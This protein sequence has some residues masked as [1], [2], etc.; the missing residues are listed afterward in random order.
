MYC[1]SCGTEERQTSQFCRACG[2]DMRTL[3]TA[4]Q[5][6]DAITIS[7]ISAREE[8]GRAIA[9]KIQTLKSASDLRKVA[10]EVLPEVEK[11]LESPA[12]RRLRRMRSGVIT[13]AV[14]LGVTVILLFGKVNIVPLAILGWSAGLLIFLIGLGI[15]LNGLLFSVPKESVPDH[16][17]DRHSLIASEQNSSNLL[18]NVEHFE[19][20]SSLFSKGNSTDGFNAQY[21]VPPPSVTEHT[22]RQLKKTEEEPVKRIT[23]EIQ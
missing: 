11:F 22:T 9:T 12:E 10:E 23:A 20:P 1:P 18:N 3:R 21:L 19:P 7:A 2:T 4:L 14:G 15:I 17:L 5:K 8:I 13:S 6:P 16:T